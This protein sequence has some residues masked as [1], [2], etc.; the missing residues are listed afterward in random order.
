M[1]VVKSDRLPDVQGL[2]GVVRGSI[3]PGYVGLEAG[4]S[5]VGDIFAWCKEHVGGGRSHTR[6]NESAAHLKPGET[7][8]LALDWHNGNRCVLVDPALSGAII[9]L[10]LQSRD[11]ELYRAM[12]EASAF[13]ARVIIDRM[14]DAGVPIRRLIACGGI[15]KKN[16]LLMQIYADV[17]QREVRVALSSETCALGAAIVGALVAGHFATIDDVQDALCQPSIESF[18]PEAAGVETYA[19]LYDIYL[20]L[21]DAFGVAGRPVELSGV[22]KELLQLRREAR[23]MQPA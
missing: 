8:L 15:A 4:Q 16:P 18:V 19:R 2:C 6:L 17:L 14:V 22:M 9:G 1:A 13:G 7:G 3:L 23:Q 10:N 12:L 20:R 11:F 21:H 5:A